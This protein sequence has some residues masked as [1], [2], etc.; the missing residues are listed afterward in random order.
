MM[1]EYT[2]QEKEAERAPMQPTILGVI[3]A[4]VAACSMLVAMVGLVAGQWRNSKKDTSDM[5]AT[6]AELKADIKYIRDSIDE[7]KNNYVRL[8]ERLGK[9]ENRVSHLEERAEVPIRRLDR[10]EEKIGLTD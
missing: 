2:Y 10:L 4:T 8:E 7:L 3:S 5:T 1:V 9:V 6:W